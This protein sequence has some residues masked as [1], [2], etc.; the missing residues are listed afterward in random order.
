MLVS[1]P[2]VTL[3][4][5]SRRPFLDLKDVEPGQGAQRSTQ[6]GRAARL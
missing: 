3:S 4:A 6:K 1:M 5:V 2:F